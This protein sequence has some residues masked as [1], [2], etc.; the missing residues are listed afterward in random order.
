[1]GRSSLCVGEDAVPD[2][3][4]FLGVPSVSDSLGVKPRGASGKGPH[5][6][7]ATHVAERLAIHP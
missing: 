1:V 5:R 7:L 3:P 6:L 2:V 4:G